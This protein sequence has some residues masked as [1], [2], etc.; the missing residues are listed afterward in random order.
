MNTVTV[1]NG[2]E[3]EFEPGLMLNTRE[4]AKHAGVS[5]STIR[6]WVERGQLPVAGKVG[7]ANLYTLAAVG[8]AEKASRDR[9]P[10]RNDPF[11]AG[12]Q[13]LDHRARNQAA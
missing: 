5:E 12:R 9:A 1:I 10:L 6:S 11:I 8:I 2:V 4:A 13:I 7:R 3:P